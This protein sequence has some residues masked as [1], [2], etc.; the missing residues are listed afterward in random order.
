MA[1]RRWARRCSARRKSGG[2]CRAWSVTGGKVCR[3]HGGG[4]PQVRQAARVRLEAERTLRVLD[5]MAE[6]A[7]TGRRLRGGAAV[8]AAR[9]LEDLTAPPDWDAILTTA[10]L[11]DPGELAAGPGKAST[12]CAAPTS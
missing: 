10:D 7:A 11:P 1:R 4:A 8:A 2:R 5:A 12:P 3:A 9:L 6:A